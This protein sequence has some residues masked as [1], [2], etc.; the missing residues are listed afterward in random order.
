LFRSEQAP[1]EVAMRAAHGD[2]RAAVG[3]ADLEDVSS[4]ALSYLILFVWQ[5]LT[6]R[7]QR[8]GLAETEA[9]RAALR[10]NGADGAHHDLAFPSGEIGV[11]LI[12]LGLADPL[13]DHL[14][15]RLRGDSAKIF[16]GHLNSDDVPD[17]RCHLF[18]L[19]RCL[20]QRDLRTLVLDRLDYFLLGEDLGLPGRRLE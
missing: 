11:E 19:A 14:L 1:Q 9:N 12:P 5:L 15:R 7:K 17:L 18:A 10:V 8:L 2:L 4:N 13:Q 20:G 6:S 3:A 16:G